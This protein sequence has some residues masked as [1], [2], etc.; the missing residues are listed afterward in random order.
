MRQTTGYVLLGLPYKQDWACGATP[1][2]CPTDCSLRTPCPQSHLPLWPVR[3]VLTWQNMEG[4]PVAQPWHEESLQKPG[5]TLLCLQASPSWQM[6]FETPH[7]S[8]AC[9]HVQRAC[10]KTRRPV[11]AMLHRPIHG[12]PEECMQL[13]PP[14]HAIVPFL[15]KNRLPSSGHV[16]VSTPSKNLRGQPH[17]PFPSAR[18]HVQ[19]C[20]V[21]RITARHQAQFFFVTLGISLP[22]YQSKQVEVQQQV[23]SC[24]TSAAATASAST[25]CHTNHF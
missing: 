19:L 15:P 20:A 16:V 13:L 18:F 8:V 23:G 9:C 11:S 17:N 21:V 1:S 4:G 3:L 5:P 14:Q 12:L 10:L 7:L 6:I 22:S 24:C 25:F 2:A